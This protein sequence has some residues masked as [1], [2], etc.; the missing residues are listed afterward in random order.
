MDGFKTLERQNVPLSPGD[1]VVVPTLTIEVG[2]LNETVTVVGDAPLIQSRSGERSF[3]VTSEAVT[4][5][6]V[7][8][9]TGFANF[10]ALAPGVT[11]LL[12]LGGGG[13]NNVM[14]DG[15]SAM[16]TG[17]GGSNSMLQ[18]NADAIAEVRVLAQSYQAE[19]GKG[20][21]LQISAVSKSGTNRFKGSTYDIER[22]SGWNANDWVNVANG[23]PKTV[24]R[25]RDWGYTIGGPVGKPGG[26]NKVFFFYSHEF[27]PRTTGGAITRFRVPTALERAGDFSQTLD[28]NGNLFNLIRDAST[29]LPCTAADPRGCFQDGGVGWQD[30]AKP[31]V[32]R[33]HE[34][35]EALADAEC[36]GHQL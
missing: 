13:Q 22:S 2:Q 29:G 21:G 28:N 24:S 14:Q 18:M 6:P 20:S 25:Q 23:D 31:A 8:R 26:R 36:L 9:A 19:F 5:M 35:P 16:D 34:H 32:R 10:A 17:G 3:T 27:R 11:G 33:R 1:R 15:V 30:S 4:N 12:R 7:S